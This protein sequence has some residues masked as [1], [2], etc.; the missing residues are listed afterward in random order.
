MPAWF[1]DELLTPEAYFIRHFHDPYTSQHQL[2]DECV[3]EN[4]VPRSTTK[5]PEWISILLWVDDR[6]WE[7][8]GLPEI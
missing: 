7:E 8:A 1:G 3:D 4:G 5:K 2:S 6:L